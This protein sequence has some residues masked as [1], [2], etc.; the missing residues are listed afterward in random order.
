MHVL[1]KNFFF[2]VFFFCFII[3]PFFVHGAITIP[4]VTPDPNLPTSLTTATESLTVRIVNWM[5]RIFWILT[6]GFLI[7]A[8]YLY[9]TAGGIEDNVTKA[10]KYIIYAL[11][12][13]AVALLAT[14]L[15]G[16]VI[17]LLKSPSTTTS[18]TP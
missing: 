17:N 8:A 12:A 7:Y 14:S 10:K 2:S 9:L 1:L 5:I 16:I 4:G 6:V 15:S 11:I 3:T 18:T 13:A